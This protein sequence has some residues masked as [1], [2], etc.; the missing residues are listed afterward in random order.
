MRIVDEVNLYVDNHKPWLLAKR[1]IKNKELNIVCTTLINSFR[2]IAIYLK[3]VVPQLV[4]KIEL[5]L[6]SAPLTWQDLDYLILDSKINNYTHLINRV[7][8][9]MIDKIIEINQHQLDAQNIDS[10]PEAE[11]IAYEKLLKLFQL[12]ILAKLICE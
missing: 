2:L 12:M 9:A 3:P 7:E 6:K 8:P 1:Q 10:K 11:N 5:F 4:A